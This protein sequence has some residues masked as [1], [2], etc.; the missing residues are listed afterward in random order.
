M[1]EL[2]KFQGE[3]RVKESSVDSLPM[4]VWD[5]SSLSLLKGTI[6]FSRSID[7]GWIVPVY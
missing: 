3:M 5:S 2:S 7:S 4:D 6:S 1:R